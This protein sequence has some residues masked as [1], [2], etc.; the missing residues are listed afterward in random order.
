MSQNKEMAEKI[1]ALIASRKD[2]ISRTLADD[3]LKVLAEEE[4]VSYPYRVQELGEIIRKARDTLARIVEFGDELSGDRSRTVELYK[5]LTTSIEPQCLKEDAEN[6]IPELL[7]VFRKLGKARGYIHEIA[8]ELSSGH[9]LDLKTEEILKETAHNLR[10]AEAVSLEEPVPWYLKYT[11]GKTFS[12]VH[13]KSGVQSFRL[14]FAEIDPNS[15]SEERD[16]CRFI[17]EQFK[18][19]MRKLGAPGPGPDVEETRDERDP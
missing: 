18:T 17:G 7:E 4:S 12:S 2:T 3:I 16:H 6:N 11:Q 14:A 15:E 10:S 1:A 19:A 8:E 9:A 13:F 5:F